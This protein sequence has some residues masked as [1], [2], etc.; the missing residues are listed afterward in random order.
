MIHLTYSH[1][2]EALFE[3]FASDLAAH[4]SGRSLFERARLVV[5]N[6]N[7]ETWLKRQLAGRDGIAA[8][9]EVLLLRRFVAGLVGQGADPL[10]LVD[11]GLLQDLILSVLLD[12]DVLERPGFAPVAAYLQGGGAASDSVDQRRVQLAVQLARLFE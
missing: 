11:S 5:P 3:K 8:N 12:P 4:R 9:F 6:R 7:V 2:T 1:R 10:Q